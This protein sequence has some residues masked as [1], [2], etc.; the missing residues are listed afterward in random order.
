[1]KAKSNDH[2]GDIGN[3][4]TAALEVVFQFKVMRYFARPSGCYQTFK[5]VINFEVA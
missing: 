5:G 2:N 4:N 1:M 3:I